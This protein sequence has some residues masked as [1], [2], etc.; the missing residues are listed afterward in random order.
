MRLEMTVFGFVLVLADA[1]LAFGGSGQDVTQQ[2]ERRNQIGSPGLVRLSDRPVARINILRQSGDRIYL[3]GLD[4]CVYSYKVDADGKIEWLSV[5][6]YRWPAWREERGE[7]LAM[8]LSDD[9]S[10]LAIGGIGLRTG[11][12]AEFD[13]ETQRLTRATEAVRNTVTALDYGSDGALV[14]GSAFG[15]VSIWRANDEV[16]RL[17]SASSNAQYVRA[18]Q[19]TAG[20]AIVLFA[21]GELLSFDRDGVGKKVAR[22]AATDGFIVSAE[23]SA[24]GER[25]LLGRRR[26]DLKS[27]I[28]EYSLKQ[29]GNLFAWRS[30]STWIVDGVG[31]TTGQKDFVAYGISNAAVVK[32]R[33]EY[34]SV[35]QKHVEGQKQLVTEEIAGVRL[36]GILAKD[37]ES[38]LYV[39]V[40]SHSLF[41]RKGG[42]TVWQSDDQDDRS[43]QL[44]WNSDLRGFAWSSSGGKRSFQFDNRQLRTSYVESDLYRH[45]EVVRVVPDLS[46]PS[47][48]SIPMTD[49]SRRAI[50]LRAAR[51]GEGSCHITYEKDGRIYVAV[52]HRFGVSLFEFLKSGKLQLMRKLIGHQQMVSAIAIS[53]DRRLLLTGAQDGTICCFTL[54]AWKHHPEL[55]A[56]FVQQGNELVVEALDDGSPIWETGLSV[57]DRIQK[58]QYEGA[59][60]STEQ[61]LQRLSN[62]E[63]GGEFKFV[64]SNLNTVVSSRV[65]QRPI[66]KFFHHDKEWILYRYRDYFYDCSLQ[67]D[68]L[69]AWFINPDTESEP[70]VVSAE[71]A[72]ERFYQPSK[73]KDLLSLDS[74]RT[75]RIQVPELVP[76]VVGLRLEEQGD[77]LVIQASMTAEENAFLVGEPQEL[78]V[79]VGDLRVAR[80][81][82]PTIPSSETITIDRKLLRNGNNR[83]IARAYNQFGV[84]G[85]SD[86]QVVEHR[87]A[88]PSSKLWGLVLGIKDYRQSRK[89]PDATDSKF[90]VPDLNWTLNDAVAMEN[91][92]K[93]NT[94]HFNLSDVRRMTDSEVTRK[95]LSEEL[96]RIRS[97]CSP[98]D[99]L[100]LSFAGHGYQLEEQQGDEPRSTFL[101]LTA[102]SSLSSVDEAIS[103]SLPIS[104]AKSKNEGAVNFDSLFDELAS[105]PCRK[106]ILM[107]A[108]HS[109]GAVEMVRA[110]T[111]DFVV[112]PSVITASGKN[113]YALEVPSKMHGIFTAAIVEAVGRKFDVADVNQ[114]QLLSVAEL[115]N[116][117]AKRVPEIFTNSEPFMLPEDFERG[118]TPEFWSPE[119][120]KTL[121]IFGKKSVP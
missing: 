69:V 110:L 26:D 70:I 82:S 97:Q 73:L 71:Q 118:Q 6:T 93:K 38:F 41:L 40:E 95:K 46:T 96:S 111:P 48:L 9:G 16:N 5:K 18:V 23:F 11:T 43:L 62:F 102:E 84:R 98:D 45:K 52:G 57:G 30:P 79:W 8:E 117:C 90:T 4:H 17:R 42:R 13:V 63:V 76:P 66:W 74:L 113:Q 81:M 25:L 53:E 3:A 21:D 80:K 31:Y 64:S 1:I 10:R 49:G 29:N 67:G 59:D 121:P 100:V 50:P 104:N 58:V 22:L 78:S 109:G 85:D 15:E 105:L 103:T 112:G 37:I 114:D 56:K 75:K 106:M 54:E 68:Q 101:M 77:K 19:W 55:G 47:L 2:E 44:F 61:A 24:D 33:I 35:L 115:Y 108:C 92:L 87:S 116:Y 72:R 34:K 60:L 12:V 28:I 89:I 32:N 7:I 51:D 120:D 36:S 86:F 39:P 119:A 91:A 94:N 20:G 27:E 88:E 107:D 99:F 83:V 14:V 65:L